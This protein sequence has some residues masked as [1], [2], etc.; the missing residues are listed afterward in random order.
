MKDTVLTEQKPYTVSG[1][2]AW[3]G[4]DRRTLLNYENRDVFFPTIMAAK[5]KIEAWQ[6][7]CL[8]DKDR[9]TRGVIF[10]MAN[11]FG[12]KDKREQ[13]VHIG[14]DAASKLADELLGGGN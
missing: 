2:A 13:D 3:L 1:L 12:W 10:S 6:E 14:K 5:Q 9:P 7:S 8:Y 4:C 11:N